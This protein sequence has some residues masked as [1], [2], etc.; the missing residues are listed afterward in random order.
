MLGSVGDRADKWIEQ[1]GIPFSLGVIDTNTGQEQPKRGIMCEVGATPALKTIEQGGVKV[2]ESC[3]AQK[4]TTMIVV[5]CERRW[6]ENATD[7]QLL[8]KWGAYL[9]AGQEGVSGLIEKATGVKPLK[10]ENYRKIVSEEEG[11]IQ[12][13]VKCTKACA[14]TAGEK[15]YTNYLTVRPYF[16]KGSVEPAEDR[17][18]YLKHLSLIHI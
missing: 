7:K 11:F 15:G 1:H 6:F 13:T 12:A 2:V 16:E 8:A 14:E 10:I 5:E 4:D 17:G 18:K 9:K 3:I